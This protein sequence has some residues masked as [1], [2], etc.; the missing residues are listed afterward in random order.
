MKWKELEFKTVLITWWA[1]FLWSHICEKL[2]NNWTKVVCVDNMQTWN[3][4]NIDIF[5][6]NKNY[7]FELIDVNEF[8]QIERIYKK[9][10]IDFV[11]HH[12]ATVWVKLTNEKPFMVFNDLEWIKHILKLSDMFWIEK[13]V[14][15][16][17]SEVYWEPQKVP[18]AED[19]QLSPHI[20]YATVKLLWEQLM[21]TYNDKKWLRTTSVRFFN[22][23]WPRQIGT[24]YWFVAWIFMNQVINWESPTV[25]WDWSQTRNFVYVDDNVNATIKSM[26]NKESDWEV[27]NIWTWRPVTVIDLA[28]KIINVSWKDLKPIFVNPAKDNRVQHRFPDITKMKKVL[29]YEPQFNLDRWLKLTYDWYLNNK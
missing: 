22:V 19:D 17:S 7:N 25:F 5:L 10:K 14:F 23:F 3:Q 28:E 27:I 29:W 20:P 9:Y 8:K 21:K 4:T 2:L 13:V 18:E 12:A 6:D 26:I 1:W 11:F 15:A 24:A 16:S